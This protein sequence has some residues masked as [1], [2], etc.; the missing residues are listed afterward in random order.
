MADLSGLDALTR[1]DG[2]V[3]IGGNPKLAITSIR[4]LLARLE[5]ALGVTR[6]D[7]ASGHSPSSTCT[8]EETPD[9]ETH[10]AVLR[11][12]DG[13]FARVP[14]RDCTIERDGAKGFALDC[15]RGAP[16]SFP[17]TTQRGPLHL[18]TV[19][20]LFALARSGTTRV[21]GDLYVDSDTRLSHLRDLT[22]LREVEG[23]LDFGV[24]DT[25]ATL[26]GLDALERVGGDL[27]IDHLDRL[28]TLDS[29]GA[30]TAVGGTLEVDGCDWLEE[31][32]GF[33][34]LERAARI[35]I[36]SNGDIRRISGFDRL[37]HLDEGLTVYRNGAL[38]TL[39]GFSKLTSVDGKVRVHNA[40][41]L[42][43]ITGLGA[44]ESAGTLELRGLPRLVDLSGLAKLRRLENLELDD[45]E[46]LTSLSGLRSL[47]RVEHNLHIRECKRL[48]SLAGL[49][50][51]QELDGGLGITDNEALT[52]LEGL[53]NLQKAH[54]VFVANND[55]L[56]SLEGLRS[57]QRCEKHLHIVNN[58]A[59]TSLAGLERLERLGGDLAI[60]HNDALRSVAALSSLQ[61]AR[62][63]DVQDNERLP[64]CRAERLLRGGL[65]LERS[66]EISENDT[67]A[68]CE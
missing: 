28:T 47:E 34:K 13:S 2:F 11:C 63:L 60:E 51:I 55:S 15:G 46:A 3:D 44:L 64:Q 65:Q 1:V 42:T 53:H 54:A 56:T 19:V 61:R 31:V 48:E 45:C 6:R 37:E 58:D 12:D 8:L 38:E 30:L 27:E 68:R 39:A 14:R 10:R 23:D 16:L 26:R 66:A 29:L 43:A 4:P 9:D 57:L 18:D 49:E 33:P 5:G 52:T 67:E 62:K 36:N 17:A 41:A 21:D 7:N 20:E 22:A 40:R 32:S 35:R 25:L 24:L 50:E 59:L